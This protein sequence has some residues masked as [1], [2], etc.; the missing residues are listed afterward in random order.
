MPGMQ[1]SEQSSELCLGDGQGY[2]GNVAVS[3]RGR[4]CLHWGLY[5]QIGPQAVSKELRAHNYCRNPNQSLKPWCRVKRGKRVVREFCDI[6]KCEGEIGPISPT[7]NPKIP[8]SSAVDTEFTCGQ[9]AERRF[10]IVGGAA[11]PI[12]AQP[13]TAAIYRKRNSFL[14]GG[15]LIAPCWVLTAAH[16]FD[17]REDTPRS[18]LSVYLGK[19]FINAA[20]A[21]KEQ[22]FSVEKLIIHKNYDHLAGTF[23]NDIALLNIKSR[24]GSCAVRTDSVRTACLVPPGTMLPSGSVCSIAG[25]GLEREK[26]LAYS[27]FLKQTEVE[28]F[29]QDTCKGPD[30]Y[31]KL[32]SDNMFCAGGPNWK[33][34]ACKGDSGGPLVCDVQGRMFLLGV[35]SWGEGCARR[36][37]P[38]VYTRVSN[39][40]QWI[41]LNTRLPAF[42][43]GVMYP[44]K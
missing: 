40:N 38:G 5:D 31:G 29:S 20:D 1:S 4:T 10:K 7:V 30:Y 44:Q 41:A 8:P 17:D 24:D 39:Y 14:C 13:W 25:Y 33:T 6:P 3:A 2:R 23:D 26:A 32:I 11:S 27:K 42:T 15:T 37:K 21:D 36:N 28:L 22:T 16:C 9:K 19:N 34:D 12:E 18:Q 35:I 43:A